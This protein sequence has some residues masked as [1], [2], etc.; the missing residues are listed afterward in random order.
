MKKFVL[1]FFKLLLYPIAV[2]L[3]TAL[4]SFKKAPQLFEA[5]EKSPPASSYTSGVLDKWMEMQ[6]KLMSTTVANFNGP[7]VRIYGYS[8][9]VAYEAIFPGISKNSSYLI[10][11]TALNKMPALP[12]VAWRPTIAG[13]E[14]S[15][16][17]RSAST[18]AAGCGR[19][20]K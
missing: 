13:N 12:V 5:N 20:M 4:L 10:P 17:R 19:L 16:W 8:G 2:S 18:L 9:L 1:L 14:V 7:F 3:L 15:N 11:P 6:I